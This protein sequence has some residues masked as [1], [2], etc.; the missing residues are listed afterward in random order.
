L[1][2]ENF[3]SVFKHWKRNL[4]LIIL[5]ISNAVLY[6]NCSGYQAQN[7]NEAAGR[8]LATTPVATIDSLMAMSD[9]RKQRA[10][11]MSTKASIMPS[12]IHAIFPSSVSEP[13]MVYSPSILN[14]L[15]AMGGWLSQS[16]IGPDRLYISSFTGKDWG[17]L[18]PVQWTNGGVPGVV[19]GY[20]ANDPS[21]V[22]I[23]S[24]MFMFY[25]LLPNQFA[26]AEQMTVFNR[27]GYASSTDGGASWTNHGIL[28]GQSNGLDHTGA[29]SLAA[30]VVGNEIW[31]YYHTGSKNCPKDVC[32][33]PGLPPRVLRTRIN[34]SNFQFVATEVVRDLNGS[35]L[36]YTNVDV[37][38]AFNG[39]YFVAN[40]PDLKNI[41]FYHSLDGLNFYSHDGGQGI[42]VGGG[43]NFLV[44][45]TQQILNEGSMNLIFNFSTRADL[46]GLSL[47]VWN[48]N[49]T[50]NADLKNLARLRMEAEEATKQAQAK[51]SEARAEQARAEAAAAL[52]QAA[53]IAKA[54]EAAAIDRANRE[55]ENKERAKSQYLAGKA[56]VELYESLNTAKSNGANGAALQPFI[57][58]CI[59]AQNNARNWGVA[60]DAWTCN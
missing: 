36:I 25:T 21:L 27:V 7:L 24:K 15:M 11:A 54:N 8:G 59:D 2:S 20:H 46:V 49:F 29:W 13:Y 12:A 43:V 22:Q 44:T 60:V 45:P 18:K 6:Q 23:G 33:G 53:E 39:F 38:K 32:Q 14:S 28:I 30:V 34:S 52:A 48:M 26:N 10:I 5:G 31:L 51:E 16:D 1:N 40:T 4:I 50:L 58:Y 56:F 42:L 55:R 47:N 57:N 17:V 41:V 19:N 9:G 3:A 37:Q 35:E